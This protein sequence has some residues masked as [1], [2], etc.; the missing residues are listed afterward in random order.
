MY[1]SV[2]WKKFREEARKKNIQKRLNMKRPR[3]KNSIQGRE[4]SRVAG[5]VRGG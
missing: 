5:F 3:E 2:R 1:F 4:N